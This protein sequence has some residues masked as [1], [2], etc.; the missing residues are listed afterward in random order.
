[1]WGF[2]CV[3]ILLT[4]PVILRNSFFYLGKKY[5][6]ISIILS[7]FS[8]F[9]GIIM[10]FDEFSIRHLVSYFA[11]LYGSIIGGPLWFSGIK[12]VW[13]F[14]K[15][16]F[17]KIKNKIKPLLKVGIVPMQLSYNKIFR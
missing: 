5:F 16:F 6:W 4:T 11:M 10:E 17:L 9:L 8:T 1:M 7:V 14:Y 13:V 12:S 3:L 2:F 15:D